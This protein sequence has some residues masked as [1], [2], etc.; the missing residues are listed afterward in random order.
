MHRIAEL[1]LIL[2]EPIEPVEPRACGF[3]GISLRCT[4]G[5]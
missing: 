3:P 1:R 5:S 4:F 2:G